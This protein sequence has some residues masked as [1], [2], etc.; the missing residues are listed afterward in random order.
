MQKK[1]T[2]LTCTATRVDNSGV[3]ENFSVRGRSDARASD[4]SSGEVLDGDGDLAGGKR[5]AAPPHLLGK[6]FMSSSTVRW[7]FLYAPAEVKLFLCG[8]MERTS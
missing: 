8:K 5:I 7:V 1:I 3:T 2:Q 4:Q 6:R